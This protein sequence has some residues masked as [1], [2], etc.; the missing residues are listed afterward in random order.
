MTLTKTQKNYI[1]L[2]NK[3]TMCSN[4]VTKYES[5]SNFNGIKL[6]EWKTKYRDAVNQ[7]NAL[8]VTDEDMEVVDAFYG[9]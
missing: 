3:V 5:G 6:S 9:C 7:L 8:E 4:N 1:K 2:S